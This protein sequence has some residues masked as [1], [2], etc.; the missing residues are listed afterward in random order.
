METKKVTDKKIQRGIIFS[1]SFAAFMAKLDS[2][3]VNISLP[4]I[5]KYFN[6]TTSQISHVV[7][8]YMIVL[9]GTLMLFGKL[10][11]KK[12]VK[13]IFITGYI[14]FV[15]GSLLCGISWSLDML[16]A[17]RFIQGIGGSM[18]FI[19]GFIILPRY[20]PVDR[21][22]WAFGLLS[23]AAALAITLGG[24]VGGLITGLASWHWIFLINVPFGIIAI[25]LANKYIP[26]CSP[27]R[28]KGKSSFDVMGAILSCIGLSLLIYTLSFGNENGWT[29]GYIQMCFLFSIITL[30]LFV[31]WEK[32]S[33]DPIFDFSIIKNKDFA[34][35]NGAALLAVM[36]LGGSS[37]LIP[38]FLQ[39]FKGL[40]VEEAGFVTLSYSLVYMICGPFAGRISDRVNPRYLTSLGMFV[41]MA[42]SL[43]FVFTLSYSGLFSV[44]LLYAFLAL[45]FAMFISPNNN[46]VMGL[47]PQGKLGVAAG[48]FQTVNFLGQT[49]GIVLFETA[50]SWDDFSHSLSGIQ[51][52]VTTE[53]NSLIMA[54]GFER[55][56][57]LSA[58]ICFISLVFSF[59]IKNSTHKDDAVPEEKI[60]N[61]N[62]GDDY[63][64]KKHQE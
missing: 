36:V 56:F 49:L 12:G 39:N 33:K 7:L 60:P 25:V 63:F 58:L 27:Q 34:F 62:K 54:N 41:A 3:I 43:F 16:I 55:A 61:K 2:S 46:M 57:L 59:F 9:T 19:S 53:T 47:A 40:A 44:I 51:S 35:A 64:E 32:K 37:F 14:I 1:V 23:T 28:K 30:I 17:S 5:A 29:S 42:S 15:L 22:G 10:A 21:T 45:A 6:A 8:I 11:D 24:P 48:I 31:L 13:K 52:S 4:D 38:F 50:Y 20:L 26:S 18:L